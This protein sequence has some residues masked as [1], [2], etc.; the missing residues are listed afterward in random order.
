MQYCV[1]CVIVAV[2]T[3]LFYK[4][5]KIIQNNN[6]NQIIFFEKKKNNQGIYCG[7]YL[8][9]VLKVSYIIIKYNKMKNKKKIILVQYTSTIIFHLTNDYVI[10]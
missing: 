1:F 9:D 3:F 7:G 2:I 4:Q 10:L 6:N 8:V 5:I